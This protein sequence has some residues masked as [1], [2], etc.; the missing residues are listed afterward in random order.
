MNL[1]I[2]IIILIIC[3]CIGMYILHHVENISRME[4][5]NSP[6]FQK[7]NEGMSN[8]Y[9]ADTTDTTDNANAYATGRNIS[10]NRTTVTHTTIVAVPD[11]KG[12]SEFNLGKADSS[13]IPKIIWTFWS[14]DRRSSTLGSVE[15]PENSVVKS[16]I[17]SWKKHNP[18][19]EIRVLTKK[20]YKK[21]VYGVPDLDIDIEK[22]KHSGD[23]VA[24]FADYV[25]CIVL[26]QHGGFW[27]DASII[28]HAP[29]S[30]VHATQN[31]TDAEFVGY[32]IHKGTYLEYMQTSPMIENWFFACVPGSLFMQDWCEEFFRTD[33]YATIAE[34]LDNVKEQGV[35]FN[36]IHNLASPEYLTMHISAQ[37]VLQQPTDDHKYN[38]YLFSCCS[39]PFAYLHDHDWN[40][41]VAVH[42][43]VDTATCENYYKYPLIK[44]RGSERTVLE[45]YDDS[46]RQR[47]FI[48]T[49]D[50]FVVGEKPGKIS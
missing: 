3:I 43:L 22:M 13:K 29:L 4:F 14:D 2:R 34:Y 9:D 42:Q 12:L 26:S 24:R 37:K 46:I 11:S 7:K 5:S 6:L 36:N 1:W 39:G 38:L 41:A 19:Y 47:A 32:Y 35:H 28:C 33:E 17:N 10:T 25:R 50:F 40:S 49:Q 27:I 48:G 16:C 21:Y 30:W 45:Q 23:F 20:N 18:D 15:G 44:L 31:K 8:L